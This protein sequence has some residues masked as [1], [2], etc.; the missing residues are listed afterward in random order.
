[1]A[2]QTVPLAAGER[3][4]AQHHRCQGLELPADAGRGI[5]AGLAR[6]VEDATEGAER[7]GQ[8]IGGEQHALDLDA[9]MARRLAAGA[10]RRQMPA[11]ARAAEKEVTDEQHHDQWPR[12]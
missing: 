11:E 4:A 8:H 10:D 5:R 9:G 7:A 6:G 2:R 3:D 1:M 12:R